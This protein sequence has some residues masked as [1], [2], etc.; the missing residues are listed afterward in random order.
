MRRRLEMSVA[1]ACPA[2]VARSR[3]TVATPGALADWPSNSTTTRDLA[4]R[5]LAAGDRVDAELAQ[6]RVEPGRGVDRAEDRVDRAVAG[7]RALDAP[8]RRG[9]TTDTVACGGR[10]EE[11]STSNHSSA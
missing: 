10:R 4:E 2:P 8:R 7:E 1:T 9:V 5:V 11:A 6:A 3:M